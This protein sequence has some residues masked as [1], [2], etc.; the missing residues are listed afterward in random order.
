M[1]LQVDI[2][3]VWTTIVSVIVALSFI[4]GASIR[5]MY[6]SVM[7]LFVVHPFDVGDALIIN[8][9]YHKVCPGLPRALSGR[10]VCPV[11]HLLL[12]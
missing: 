11:W 7:F 5:N 9:D 4:F 12:C 10:P 8:N 6:E 2:S 3:Q 1:S